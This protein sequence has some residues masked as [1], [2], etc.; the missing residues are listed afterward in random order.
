MLDKIV[1][2]NELSKLAKRDKDY[3]LVKV[4]FEKAY[5]YVS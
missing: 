5:D 3:L 4:Y 2:V 1:V